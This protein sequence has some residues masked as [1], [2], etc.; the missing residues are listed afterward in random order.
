MTIDTDNYNVG[1]G[2]DIDTTTY[3]LNVNGKYYFSKDYSIEE[4]SEYI[5]NSI[6]EES[7]R[8]IVLNN[9]YSNPYVSRIVQFSI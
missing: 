9:Y 2:E 1:I 4:T 3:K 6:Y 7:D 5:A 8:G